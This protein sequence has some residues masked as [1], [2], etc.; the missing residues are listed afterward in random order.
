MDVQAH[1]MVW[2]WRQRVALLSLFSLE[3]Q[4]SNLG[5]RLL[6]QMTTHQL[7]SLLTPLSSWLIVKK[8]IFFVKV[9]ESWKG[10]SVIKFV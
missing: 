9:C 8:L 10:T 5:V 4:G 1:A 6:G 2:M 7:R 3:C